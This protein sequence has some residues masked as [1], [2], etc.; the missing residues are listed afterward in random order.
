MS[1]E[2]CPRHQRAS[3]LE[4]EFQDLKRLVLK[5]QPDPAVAQFTFL[6]VN[7][8]GAK[9]EFPGGGAG[10]AKWIVVK[11]AHGMLDR[12]LRSQE[13]FSDSLMQLLD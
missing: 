3:L 11:R 6:Q 4:Q 8:E 10:G 12:T 9:S 5:S 13:L 7:F 1:R 2:L